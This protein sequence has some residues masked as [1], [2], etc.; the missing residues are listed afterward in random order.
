MKIIH[1]ERFEAWLFSQPDTRVWNYS[2][3]S[4]CLACCFL[5]ETGVTKAASVVFNQ[6]ADYEQGSTYVLQDMPNWLGRFIYFERFSW[7][8][9]KAE[10][11]GAMA[12]EGYRRL[13]N[14]TE[15]TVAEP[16]KEMEYA[17]RT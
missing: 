13:F 5:N 3:S 7:A 9:G 4:A 1:Q 11:T 12:K 8:G 17:D 6:W 16:I 2:D 15:E 14:L 10:L